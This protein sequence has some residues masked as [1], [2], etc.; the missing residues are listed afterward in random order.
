MCFTQG[1]IQ[2]FQMMLDRLKRQDVAEKKRTRKPAMGSFA[3][4]EAE[5]A[6][7]IDLNDFRWHLKM[8]ACA[9]LCLA[10]ECN[11]VLLPVPKNLSNYDVELLKDAPFFATLYAPIVLVKGCS[12]DNT[13]TQI[14]NVRWCVLNLWCQIL[15]GNKQ[16]LVP[17]G[18]CFA[19]FIL[20]T[21]G[22]GVTT[23]RHS[24]SFSATFL[25]P[26]TQF[27]MFFLNSF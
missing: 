15:V 21:T 17:C 20:E 26:K 5:D 7:I 9:D 4:T 8:I 16:E 22:D 3:W 11:M 13:N 23:N 2:V 27:L 19:K 10:L 14:M 18:H 12:I 6:E 1:V 25:A 24:L